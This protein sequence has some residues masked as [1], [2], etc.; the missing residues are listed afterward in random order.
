MKYINEMPIYNIRVTYDNIN[1]NDIITLKIDKKQKYCM[2]IGKTETM[3]RIK[4]L[5]LEVENNKIYFTINNLINEIT[6]NYLSFSRKIYK[7]E[8]VIHEL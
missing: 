3:I 2:V 4:N 1:V 7:L 8:N 5:D 6:N